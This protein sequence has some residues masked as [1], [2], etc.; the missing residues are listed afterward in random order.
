MNTSCLRKILDE[1]NT[2]PEELGLL[3]GVSGMTVRRWVDRETPEELSEIYQTAI[4]NAVLKLIVEGKL[5]DDSA[6]VLQMFSNPEVLVQKATI[7]ALGFPEDLKGNFENQQDQIT[8]GLMHIGSQ[9]S[10]RQR[11]DGQKRKI[12]G[13]K[14]LGA[15]WSKRISVLTKVISSP[16]L[17]VLDKFMAYGALFYLIM[18]F[19]L[20]PDTVPVFGFLDD[21][22][23]LGIATTYYAKRMK[24]R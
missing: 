19:D 12:Q 3:I 23:I 1:S 4:R 22:A 24:R 21:F 16:R 10:R 18:I 11:V 15:E 2:S 7:K 17:A 20:I 6:L 9:E 5:A 8:M 14:K 13:F